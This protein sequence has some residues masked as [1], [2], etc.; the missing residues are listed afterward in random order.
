MSPGRETAS[1]A[2]FLPQ[3]RQTRTAQCAGHNL[4]T[5]AFQHRVVCSRASM[6]I[7]FLFC[8]FGGGVLCYPGD[9]HQRVCCEARVCCWLATVFRHA[10]LSRFIALPCTGP[11]PGQ[12]HWSQFEGMHCLQSRCPQLETGSFRTS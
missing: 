11:G 5:P 6:K 2:L 12:A 1:E 10:D 8:F 7:H 9:L 4:Q 3:T